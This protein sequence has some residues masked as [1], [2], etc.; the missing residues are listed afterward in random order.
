MDAEDKGFDDTAGLEGEEELR[1]EAMNVSMSSRMM[2]WM[3]LCVLLC[4]LASKRYSGSERRV[5]RREGQDCGRKMCRC[6]RLLDTT[7][8]R[9]VLARA[10][11]GWWADWCFV[12]RRLK[13][14][15]ARRWMLKWWR[16]SK[17]ITALD[18]PPSGVEEG[19]EA[20]RRA[21]AMMR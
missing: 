5:A 2:E 9:V 21:W 7:V 1:I 4:W 14:T 15:S 18:W 8:W 17:S 6:V 3:R 19:R 20:G 11:R 12:R 10:S 13:V 16:G